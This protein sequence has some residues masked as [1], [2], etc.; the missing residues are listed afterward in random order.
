MFE[1]FLKENPQ[2]ETGGIT[3]FAA[4]AFCNWLSGKLPPLMAAWEVRLPAE[5]E[6]EYAARAGIIEIGAGY[7]EW[8]LDPYT[9]LPFIKISKWADETAGSPERSLRSK[10]AETRASLPPEFSSPVV[11]FR[12]VIAVKNIEN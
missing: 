12:P 6:W 10:D 3:W 9:P 8:C 11:T 4:Q 2:W 5:A 1:V 7:W